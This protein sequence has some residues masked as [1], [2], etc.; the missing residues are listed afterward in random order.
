MNNRGQMRKERLG[1]RFFP[2]RYFSG[3][4]WGRKSV[5]NGVEGVDRSTGVTLTT[6]TFGR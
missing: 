6:S 5:V 2:G 1:S 4:G 3:G